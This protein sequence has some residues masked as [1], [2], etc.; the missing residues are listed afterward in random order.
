V[1]N[2][3][4]VK[5]LGL[6]L[7]P[8]FLR[9]VTGVDIFDALNEFPEQSRDLIEFDIDKAEM[10][11]SL[12][13]SY[14]IQETIDPDDLVYSIFSLCKEAARR[15]HEG[16]SP[17]SVRA[18]DARHATATLLTYS[19]LSVFLG[20]HSNR[21]KLIA[22]LFEQCRSDENINDK[23]LFWLQYSI[24][25]QAQDN[26]S[27]AERHMDTAYARASLR[28]S[29]QT[30]QLDTNSFC[31]YLELES[32]SHGAIERF[33][34]IADRLSKFRE[35]LGDG[36]HRGHV[37]KVLAEI[38]GFLQ[39]RSGALTNA[40]AAHLTYELNLIIATLDSYDAQIKAETGSESA[41]NSLRRALDILLREG[42]L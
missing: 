34:L 4:I 30:Y 6:K 42:R 28:P 23:P 9:V 39:R 27:V 33:E 11:S 29:F 10:N 15:I 8:G 20:R 2:S 14:I 41:K 31:L 26:W 3:L 25:M 18:R 13:S 36:N 24:F 21:D 37:M 40:E 7:D 17:Q 35:M 19:A 32:R 5:S 1:E 38:E 12:L 16:G 22:D